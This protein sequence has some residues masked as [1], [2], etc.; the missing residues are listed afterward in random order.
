VAL[1]RTEEPKS[2]TFLEL[3]FDVVF[4]LALAQ[5]SKPLLDHLSWTSVARTLIL[6]LPLSVIWAVTAEVCDKFDPRRVPIRALVLGTLLATVVMAAAAPDA[7]GGRGLYFVGAYLATQFGTIGTLVPLLRGDELQRPE[8]RRV[9]WYSVSAV[10]WIAGA[11]MHGW[12]RGV[13]W[14]LAVA[15]EY[16]SSTLRLPTPG[17]GRASVEEFGYG[18]EH[19]AD[20]CRQFITIAFGEL[21]LAT[22]LTLDRSGF[23]VA[24]FVAVLTAFATTVLLWQIYTHSPR[25]LLVAA[26]KK[27]RGPVRARPVVLAHPVAPHLS[28]SIRLDTHHRPGSP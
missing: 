11:L 3:L 22:G 24:Q 17:L 2:A 8:V 14:V 25:E 4:V 19:L 10:P 12:A 23:Q 21:V 6:L 13:L 9:F 20:R 16:M 1:L 27:E 18:G 28:S 26:L 5:L 7:F 15:V